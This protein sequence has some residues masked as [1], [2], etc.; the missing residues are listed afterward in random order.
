MV[1]GAEVEGRRDNSWPYLCV[2][3]RAC[4]RTTF[5]RKRP[6]YCI[7]IIIC[8]ARKQRGLARGVVVE[9]GVSYTIQPL[10]TAP[11]KNCRVQETFFALFT[12]FNS[13]K[14]FLYFVTDETLFIFFHSSIK[15]VTLLLLYS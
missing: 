2:K 9:G 1:V 10:Q 5:N 3:R 11:Y 14:Q 13:M 6:L 12:C 7:G 8:L 4:A 15:I